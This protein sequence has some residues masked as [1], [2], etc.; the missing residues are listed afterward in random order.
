M[1]TEQPLTQS[2]GK[3]KRELDYEKL[4]AEFDRLVIK[5]NQNAVRFNELAQELKDVQEAYDD[6]NQQYLAIRSRRT[7]AEIDFHADSIP[8]RSR[9]N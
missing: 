3:R 8:S 6:L 4:K 5:Y 1:S 7:Q 9:L 2:T